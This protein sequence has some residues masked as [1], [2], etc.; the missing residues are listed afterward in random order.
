MGSSSSENGGVKYLL[1][2]ID[3]VTKYAWVKALK[4]KRAKTVRHGFIGILSNLN[5]NQINYG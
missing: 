3:V 4:D 2:V 1:C 5:I